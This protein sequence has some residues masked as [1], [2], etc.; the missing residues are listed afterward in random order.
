MLRACTECVCSRPRSTIQ[1][2][3]SAPSHFKDYRFLLS[4][5]THISLCAAHSL[6]KDNIYNLLQLQ[7]TL[8]S[9]NGTTQSLLFWEYPFPNSTHFTYPNQQKIGAT[10]HY[11]RQAALVWAYHH[12]SSS[13]IWLQTGDSSD[14]SNLPRQMLQKI[15]V[16][17]SK[18]TVLFPFQADSTMKNADGSAR[19]TAANCCERWSDAFPK[20]FTI[21]LVL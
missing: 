11:L 5:S 1:Y 12:F 3:N 17:F 14:I 20:D 18:G 6:Q 4:A 13:F 9:Q 2:P 10:I 7:Y 16:S 19:G 8:R 15:L 21:L